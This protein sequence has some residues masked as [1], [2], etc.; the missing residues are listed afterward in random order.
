MYLEACLQ[1]RRQ[2]SPFLALMDGLLGVE[3]MATLKRI[4][5]R[6]ATKWRQPYSKTCGY[7]NS[8]VAI[9]LV[10]TTNCCLCGSWVPV[11]HI[12]VQ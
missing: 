9:T 11:H 2:F 6:L 1:Q 10:R 4:A 12:S 3:E 5:S 7:V 8:R